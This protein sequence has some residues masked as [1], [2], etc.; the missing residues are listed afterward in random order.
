MLLSS[1]GCGHLDYSHWP[2]QCSNFLSWSY[3]VSQG[4]TIGQLLPSQT[5]KIT[6]LITNCSPH[7]FYSPPT[8]RLVGYWLWKPRGDSLDEKNLAGH[9]LPL[10][11][12]QPPLSYF[13]FSPAVSYSS[14]LL[15]CHWSPRWLDEIQRS[16]PSYSTSTQ[17][18]CPSKLYKYGYPVWSS[19]SSP[20]S[21]ITKLS[22]QS[23]PISSNP[24]AATLI[25]VSYKSAISYWTQKGQFLTQVAAL[26][27]WTLLR[28][29]LHF[30]SPTYRMWLTKFPLTSYSYMAIISSKM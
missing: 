16:S 18:L 21:G 10:L 15:L 3:P 19:S 7:L 8:N 6:C 25:H 12:C 20:P 27:D 9:T 29:V 17:T 1:A 4:P 26:V 23:I 5:P 13:Q 14:L 11:T 2:V 24:Q 30:C 22:I 28:S